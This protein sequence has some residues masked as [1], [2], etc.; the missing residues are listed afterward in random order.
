[1]SQAERKIAQYLNDAHATEQGLVRTLQAQIAMTPHGRHRNGLEAHL[2]QTK[3]HA[4]KVRERLQELDGARNPLQWGIGLLQSA[5]EQ[6]LALSQTPLDL[7][8]GGVGG[9]EKV[10]ENAKDACASEALEIAI[11]TALERAAIAVGDEQTARLAS[12]IRADEQKMLD[13][14]LGEL[15]K[16]TEAA[17]DADVHGKRSYDASETGAADAVREVG[18]SVKQAARRGQTGVG[19]NG[20]RA[21]KASRRTSPRAEEPWP[22]YDELSVEEVRSALDREHNGE[23]AQHVRT[24][25]RAH[26]DRAGVLSATERE[27]VN[28]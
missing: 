15:P 21:R 19:R 24:Y 23:L 13:R 17:I 5:F 11:Y 22:G 4:S 25:E 28:H 9:E 3:S 26:K 2:Q 1:M 14:L 20:R 18:K 6:A 27:T 10:L 12:S 8:R 7:V 16:L